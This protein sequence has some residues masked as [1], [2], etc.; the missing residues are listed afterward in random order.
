[1]VRV[2]VNKSK[3]DKCIS[4]Y[5]LRNKSYHIISFGIRLFNRIFYV[6]AGLK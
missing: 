2:F 6:L 4:D 5:K 1:M 3:F